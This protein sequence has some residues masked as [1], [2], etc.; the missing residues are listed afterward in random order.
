MDNSN[1]LSEINDSLIHSNNEPVSVIIKRNEISKSTCSENFNNK[2]I[3]DQSEKGVLNQDNHQE[4]ANTSSVNEN[5]SNIE[6]LKSTF[7]NKSTDDQFERGVLKQ[8]NHTSQLSEMPPKNTPISTPEN[9]KKNSQFPSLASPRRSL[10]QPNQEQPKQK[11]TQTL[12]TKENILS[13]F[14]IL[15][16]V[17]CF[18]YFK[19]I[20]SDETIKFDSNI[21]EISSGQG[22]TKFDEK[23]KLLKLKYPNLTSKFWANIESTYRH[24]IV[25]S[26]DPS[27]VLI[28]N[29]KSNSRLAYNISFDI[30]NLIK[31]SIDNEKSN[32]KN[33]IINSSDLNSLNDPKRVKIEIDDK[34]NNLFSNGQKVALIRNIEFIPAEVM[35]LFM[36]YGDDFANAK[37]TGIIILMT[38]EVDKLEVND[39]DAFFK[40]SRQ[41]TQY[42]ESYLFNLWSKFIGEDQLKPIFTRIANN[43][44]FV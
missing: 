27:I 24:S 38:L 21:L 15:I 7:N 1:L 43:V 6:V 23:V 4:K 14:I 34:L 31:T 36:S 13:I 8:D 33:L 12:I 19:K 22:Q 42:I 39:R 11:K 2:S 26:R 32:I 10:H 29:E 25:K 40:S 9:N 44:I 28:A 5:A 41:M 37:Y 16:S 30:L 17:M 35:L 20:T 18:S 3:D